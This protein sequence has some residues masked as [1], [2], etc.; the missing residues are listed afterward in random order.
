LKPSFNGG[1]TRGETSE[2]PMNLPQINQQAAHM[3]DVAESIVSGKPLAISGAEGLQ[4]LRVIEAIKRSI[5][6]GRREML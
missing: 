5:E 2:G 1:D 6:T 3:D 4:D